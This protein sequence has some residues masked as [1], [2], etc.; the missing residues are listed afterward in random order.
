MQPPPY[1]DD[2]KY[3]KDNPPPRYEELLGATSATGEFNMVTTRT[4]ITQSITASTTPED[5]S[6][7]LERPLPQTIPPQPTTTVT[8]ITETEDVSP[9]SPSIT[10]AAGETSNSTTSVEPPTTSITVTLDSPEQSS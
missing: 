4:S 3:R 8:T 10:T 9:I 6:L 1:T 7:E 2:D 5:I